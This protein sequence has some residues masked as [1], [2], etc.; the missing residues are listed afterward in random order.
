MTFIV[1][2]KGAIDDAESNRLL[3]R[4]INHHVPKSMPYELVSIAG[5]EN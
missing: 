3:R 4:Q 5:T 2:A 1:H